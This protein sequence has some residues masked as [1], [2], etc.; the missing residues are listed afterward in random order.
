M[1]VGNAQST[2]SWSHRDRE[3]L[4][5]PF[6]SMREWM[7][8]EPLV[9]ERAEGRYLYDDK[10][11]SYFDA[12]SSLWVTVHGHSHPR[13]VS[14]IAEQLARLDHSTMLGLTHPPAIE[15]AERL[16]EL[17]PSGLARVFYSDSGST[18]VEIALKQAFQYWA[19]SGTS[20]KRRF[21]HLEDSYHGDTLG[22][23]GVGGIPVF[24]QVF[25]ALVV[26]GV[27]LPSPAKRPGESHDQ[28][29]VRAT[30]ELEAVLHAHHGE[31]AAFVIEPLVQGAAGML[32]H[33]PGYLRKAA[34]LCREYD[35]LLIADE[36]ATGFGRTGTMFACEQE[37][38]T[39]D[40][41]CVAKG[42]TG[43][44]LPLAATL[45]TDRVFQAFNRPRRELATFFHGHT[46]TGNPLACAAALANLEL[47]RTERTLEH[48]ARLSRWLTAALQELRPLPHVS[49]TRQSGTM[50]GIDIADGARPFPPDAF[51]GTAVSD[52][53]REQ[54]VIMR[55][56]GDTLVWMPPLSTTENEVALL[57]R[58]TAAAI[59][60]VCPRLASSR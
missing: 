21:L 22:A 45:S 57:A 29:L 10:G 18:A 58:A 16:I 12:V 55:P 49:D 59:S 36:V 24:H 5:H 60:S 41:L 30:A 34:E 35:V 44:A 54:G 31:L 38:V 1:P 46:Y 17:A 27:S 9:I 37:G 11:R 48:V 8:G 43:G 52:A 50:V 25:G 51:A 7:A 15:L 42:L 23:V 56:L 33:P 19:L 39:P 53:A 32:V 20:G 6:T 13:I 3:V 14:A 4:W 2:V 40:L 47:F 28:A 26:A